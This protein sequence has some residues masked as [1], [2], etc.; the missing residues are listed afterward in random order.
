MSFT[1]DD[2]YIFDGNDRV[3]NPQQLEDLEEFKRACELA[4]N[5]EKVRKSRFKPVLFILFTYFIEPALLFII[6]YASFKLLENT[7]FEILIVIIFWLLIVFWF[8][9]VGLGL[10]YSDK[11]SFAFALAYNMLS[12][13]STKSVRWQHN[14]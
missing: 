11:N 9:S 8:V 3:I 7:S 4:K 12:P 5:P 6:F 13:A 1:F 2:R 14:Y 10:S